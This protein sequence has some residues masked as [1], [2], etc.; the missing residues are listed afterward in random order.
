M[1]RLQVSL[2]LVV[3]VLFLI[4][5]PQGMKSLDEM[6][7]Q[8]KAVW[9]L[10]VYNAQYDDYLF[11]VDKPDLTEDDKKILREKKEILKEVYPLIELYTGYVDSGVIP[12]LE[13]ETLIMQNI[14]RLLSM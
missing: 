1:R 4:G 5:C 10:S 14:D 13:T 11:Q 9:M 2:V 7:P 12:T 3:A 6:T 8:E